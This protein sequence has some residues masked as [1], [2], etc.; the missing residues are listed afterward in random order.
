MYWF[1][2]NLAPWKDSKSLKRF[3]TLK[4]EEFSSKYPAVYETVCQGLVYRLKWKLD[5]PNGKK[6][7]VDLVAQP[8]LLTP[9]AF[10][11][12]FLHGTL[13]IMTDL[14]LSLTVGAK[15]SKRD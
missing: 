11:K 4:G 7:M 13:T 3:M 6:L 2:D 15:L 10:V 1:F 14:I 9:V 12:G 5:D 8:A